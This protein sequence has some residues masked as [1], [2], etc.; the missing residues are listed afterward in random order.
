[1]DP[2]VIIAIVGGLF[3][4]GGIAA[5]LKTR[6]D[7]KQTEANAEM[8]LTG[9]W[10]VLYQQSRQE[11]NELRERIALLEKSDQDCKTRLARLE[12]GGGIDIEKKVVTLI[13]AEIEKREEE[14]HDRPGGVHVQ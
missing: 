9:G 13:Q 4:A 6:A 1:M 7:N 2:A 10:Q 3:G 14:I 12:A 5:I 11:N 8:T